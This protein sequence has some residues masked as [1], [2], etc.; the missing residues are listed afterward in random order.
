[1][2]G[3]LML[4]KVARLSRILATIT[5]ALLAATAC[6]T[7]ASSP[8]AT[9]T[10]KATLSQAEAIRMGLAVAKV[11]AP[12]ISGALEEPRSPQSEL[13]TLGDAY[14]RIQ[15]SETFPADQSPDRAV[16]L[17]SLEGTW[18]NAFPRPTDAP[19]PM[20]YHHFRMA[21]DANTRDLIA[22]KVGP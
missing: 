10:L 13:M 4:G 11:G 9:P 12:E 6:V 2:D 5:L 16:W 20:Q 18:Q 15:W 21:L 8:P 17:V 19:T 3:R 1:M 7:P 22:L 14:R